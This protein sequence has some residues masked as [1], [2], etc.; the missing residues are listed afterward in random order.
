MMRRSFRL[1]LWAGLLFGIVFAVVKAMQARRL[2]PE[3]AVPSR[4]PWPPV[5]P[6]RTDLAPQTQPTVGGIGRETPEPT[7]T[8]AEPVPAEPVQK[9]AKRQRPLR[10]PSTEAPSGPKEP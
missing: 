8:S 9:A 1:G 5:V 2:S 4:D 6:P 10:P 7:D 3:V